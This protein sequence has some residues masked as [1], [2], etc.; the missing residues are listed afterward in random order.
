VNK[1]RNL[2]AI[3]FLIWSGIK[4]LPFR[5]KIKKVRAAGDQAE[6]TRLIAEVTARWSAYVSKHFDIRYEITGKEN[7][8]EGS[9]VFIANHQAY[10]DIMALLYAVSGKQTGFIAKNEFSKV[11]LLGKWIYATRGLFI[12]RGDVR[13]SLKTINEGAELIN[14]G[15]SLVIFP[16]GTRSQKR[17]IADFKPGSFKLATKAKAPVVPIVIDGTYKVFEQ[18][19]KVSK[20]ET[21]RVTILPAI[22]TASLDR[23]SL[24]ALPNQIEETIK[25][26]LAADAN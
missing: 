24:A 5:S 9:C 10:F 6:E 17:E 22:D 7:L 14:Q 25:E 12:K 13:E 23:K 11:P 18:K 2:G 19:R 21:V 15:F 16:E 3:F 4:F 1:T 8:P 20:G 26:R